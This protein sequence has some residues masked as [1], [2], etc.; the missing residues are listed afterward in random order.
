M[1]IYEWRNSYKLDEISNNFDVEAFDDAEE[2]QHAIKLSVEC[3]NFNIFAVIFNELIYQIIHRAE[4]ELNANEE[5]FD[6]EC[7]G[8]YSHIYFKDKEV[9]CWDD[10]LQLC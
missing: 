10:I 9:K 7:A 3:G 6:W 2:M 8:C 1:F 5:N 4:T